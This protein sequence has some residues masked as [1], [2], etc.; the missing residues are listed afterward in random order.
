MITKD[1]PLKTVL[2]LGSECQRRGHCCRYGSGFLVKED[3][4]KIA[5]YLNISK[6]EL[7]STYLEKSTKFN[8]SLYRP[9]TQKRNKPY[10]KCVFLRQENVCIIHPVKP[11]HCKIMNCSKH[12]EALSDWFDL[13]F[14]VNPDDPHSIREWAIRLAIKPTIP[15]GRLHELV[16]DKDRLD[17]IFNYQDLKP[18]MEVK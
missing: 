13:N 11:L 3:L 8:T 12:S 9:K 1:T 14:F 18:S 17:K 7:I 16:P 5:E 15:G 6:Q 10:G 2:K 4:D